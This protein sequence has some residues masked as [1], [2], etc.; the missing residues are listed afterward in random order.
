V[1]QADRLL[2]TDGCL[3]F[4]A[5]PADTRFT[6]EFNFYNAHYNATHIVATNAG[7]TDDIRRSLRMMTEGKLSP[8]TLV[9]HVGGL[10]SVM[11][12]TCNLPGLPGHK[13]LIYTHLDM[14]LTAIADFE[15]KGKK[16]K[17][18]AE[19]AMICKRNH[20][21]WSAEAEEYLLAN[22]KPI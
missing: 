17:I 20:G 6:A 15:E 4:F 5:G 19:L 21:L 13:K 1:E 12:A 7:N 22:G 11:Y 9:S 16:D 8:A 18:F 3:N 10:N 2:A 14:P